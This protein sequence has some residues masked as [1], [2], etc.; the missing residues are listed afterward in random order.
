MI[1]NFPVVNGS[2][3]LGTDT[4]IPTNLAGELNV[5]IIAF[6]RWHQDLV[7]SWVPFLDQM[8]ERN[9][10]I[11]YYELPTIRRMNW[12]YRTMLDGGMKAGIPNPETR[13]RTIT[14]Y[15]EKKS[16]REDLGIPDESDI[17]LFLV[18][19][20]GEIL[21]RDRGGFSEDKKKKLL[22]VLGTVESIA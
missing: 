3:L 2:N 6:Q 17:H 14:L 18:R 13:R 19:P 22:E 12:L 10:E 4:I 16:F 11:D 15:L 1:S 21:W 9:P 7:D 5:V 8:S 20:S